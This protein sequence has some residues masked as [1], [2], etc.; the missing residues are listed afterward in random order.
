MNSSS[1]GSKLTT[2]PTLLVYWHFLRSRHTLSRNSSGQHILSSR[3]HESDGES[4]GN[5]L[6]PSLKGKMRV[7]KQSR[8]C[9][10]FQ[11]LNVHSELWNSEDLLLFRQFLSIWLSPFLF[12][13][14]PPLHSKTSFNTTSAIDC[15]TTVSESE[16]LSCS[17][18]STTIHSSQCHKIHKEGSSPE[19]TGNSPGNKIVLSRLLTS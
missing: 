5:D 11:I 16:L 12:I 1:W 3:C 14:S 13:S 7:E 10:Q 4:P 15:Y 17:N 2:Q 9:Q 6:L 8:V 18:I 19:L